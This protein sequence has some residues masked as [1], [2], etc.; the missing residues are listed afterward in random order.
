MKVAIAGASGFVGTHIK[1]LY[2]NHVVIQREDSEDEIVSKLNGVDVVINLAGAPIIH[3]WSEDYKQIL[4]DS[5]V[6]TTRRLVN[7]MK[8]SK[9]KQF[10]STSAIGAY[11][12]NIPYDETF[13]SYATDFLGYVT[14]EW[15]AEALKCDKPTAIIRFG[16]VL[17]ADGGAL[18]KMLLPFKL[19]VGGVIGDGKMM[20]S[21]IDIDDLMGIYRYIIDNSLSGIFNG[22]SPQPVTNYTFT[23]ALGN[24]LHR[25]TIFPLPEFVLSIIF[26]EGSSVLTGSKEIYPKAISDAGFE[27]EYKGIES[28]LEH[29]LG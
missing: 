22:V 3:R 19:G 25:P 2:K 5:R 29:L 20:M 4:L 8:R 16:V 26:G 15:E 23:K 13:H 17:G 9:V 18:L 11:P 14:K 27:F 10:V 12:D 1:E 7:A 24:V 6:I 21:W 28:S